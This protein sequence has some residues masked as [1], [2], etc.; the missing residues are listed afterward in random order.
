MASQVYFETTGDWYNCLTATA[1]GE[2]PTSAPAKWER[3]VIPLALRDAIV[4]HATASLLYEDGQTDKAR[5]EFSRAE[6]LRD[7]TVFR[8]ADTPEWHH[9][10]H[11]VTR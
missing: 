8:H 11:V 4:A 1:A 9:R 3:L 7:E 2:S 10:P 6:R 5:L